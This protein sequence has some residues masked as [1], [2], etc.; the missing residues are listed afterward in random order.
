LSK[1]TFD[2]IDKKIVPIE[3]GQKNLIVIISKIVLDL[4]IQTN[5]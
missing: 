2:E 3:V 1:I 4:K 5:I